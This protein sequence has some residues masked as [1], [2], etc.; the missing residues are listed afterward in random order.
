MVDLKDRFRALDAIDFP[1][2]A[3]P[4]VAARV[5]GADRRLRARYATVIVALVIGAGGLIFAFGVLRQIG[6]RPAAQ[7]SFGSDP[8]R[9]STSAQPPAGNLSVPDLVGLT[10][11]QAMRALDDLDL[12]WV[13]AFRSV[14]GVDTWR[15]A[16]TD[17]A[18]GTSVQ[19]GATVRLVV[20]TRVS[21]LDGDVADA[22][23]C[24]PARRVEFGGPHARALPGGA[25]YITANLPGIE[26][27]DGVTH[28]IREEKQWHGIWH[29]VRD[30]AVVAV[31][32]Y[33]LLDGQACRGSG[34]AA[35]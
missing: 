10:D 24:P 5:A 31:V 29:I 20:A 18:A 30:G 11:Q 13:A 33:P 3:G 23:G 21:P 14:P 15:V 12:R 6:D 32:D 7:S 4:P 2:D 34:V 35:A 26:L 19:R 8:G 22:L 1:H 9:S 16:S 25:A 27:T 17:P 28:V